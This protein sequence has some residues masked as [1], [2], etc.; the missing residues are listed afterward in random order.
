MRTAL[1]TIA[2]SIS[3]TGCTFFASVGKAHDLDE[4]EIR[5]KKYHSEP[6]IPIELTDLLKMWMAA[7]PGPYA[8]GGAQDIT[9]R[10]HLQLAHYHLQQAML[11]LN[12]STDHE[13]RTTP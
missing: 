4:L 5:I 12:R 13:T 3:L 6:N 10:Q 2:V 8:A 1:L 9:A 11:T 7:Q